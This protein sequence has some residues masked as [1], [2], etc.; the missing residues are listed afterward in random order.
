MKKVLSFLVSLLIGTGL[1]IWTTRLIGWE[2]ITS[3]FG[4]FTFGSGLVILIL[5][6]LTILTR[7]WRWQT[8]LRNRGCKIPI[9]RI[10]EYYLSGNAIAFFVPMVIFGGEIF[11]GYDLKEKYGIPWSKSIASVFVDRILELT[12]YILVA[13]FG[14]IFFLFNTNF[15]PYKIAIIIA[16]IA[17]IVVASTVFF[18]LKS[19]RRESIIHFFLKKLNLQ[20]SGGADTALEAEKEIFQ[21]FRPEK[22]TMWKGFA[23]SFLVELLLLA[24]TFLLIIFLGKHV[25]VISAISVVAFSSLAI[26]LPIPAALGSHDAVQSFV[27]TQLGLGAGAGAA[28]VLVIRAAE[29]L[30]ALAGMLFF[31]KF[32]IQFLESFIFQ[33]IDK[34]LG[35]A[36]GFRK[37]AR[38]VNI[39][40]EDENRHQ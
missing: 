2:K 4:F 24:R 37:S 22:K 40:K 39:D 32:G 25:S 26:I 16:V 5:T 38:C 21:Y 8:I 34:L 1:L 18:Y 20:K 27:F 9:L 29:F 7:A 23:L 17:L 15:P 6:F 33:K 12:V 35:R 13:I 14:I 36:N 3:S 30:M 10:F 11:R 28:F 19:F 31:F